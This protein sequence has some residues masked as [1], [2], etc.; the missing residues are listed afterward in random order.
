M[1]KEKKPKKVA[2]D[3]SATKL[4]SK[5]HCNFC[6]KNQVETNRLI[7]GPGCYIC[8]ECLV[9]CNEIID[10][11]EHEQLV[12]EV[13]ELVIEFIEHQNKIKVAP[14]KPEAKKK[15]TKKKK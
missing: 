8:D 14:E 13:A 3:K 4:S 1:K 2:S 12:K 10:E 11:N 15:G 9:L 6:G 7:A 5:L